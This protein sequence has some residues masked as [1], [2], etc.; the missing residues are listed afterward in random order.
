LKIGIVLPQNHKPSNGGGFSYV[1]ALVKEICKRKSD[2]DIQFISFHFQ[3]KKYYQFDASAADVAYFS[4]GQQL[5]K[6][7]ILAFY[8]FME[9]LSYK[10]NFFSWHSFFDKKAQFCSD[11]IL[12]KEGFR[13]LYYPFPE[14]LIG[15]DVPFFYTVWDLGHRN[16]GFFPDVASYP[17]FDRR[18]ARYTQA[19]KRAAK[20][21]VESKAGGQDVQFYYQV[22]SNKIVVLPMFGNSLQEAS[23]TELEKQE[24]MDKNKIKSKKYLFYPAQFWPHKN[25]INLLKAFQMLKKQGYDLQLLFTGQDKGNKGLIEKTAKQLNIEDAVL[26]LGFVDNKYIRLLYE[27]AFALVMPTFLGPTNMPLVEAM[28]LGCPVICTDFEG[29]REQTEDAALYFNP[30]SPDNI[31]EKILFLLQHEAERERMIEKGKTQIEQTKA[32]AQSA[33]DKLFVEIDDFKNVLSAW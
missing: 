29:H 10:L 22:K 32:T 28:T 8:L 33:V 5:L 23:Y 1:D 4:F 7:P 17:E 21:F 24:F 6:S 25:H 16:I 3:P 26:Y 12:K 31:A 19:T 30:Q 15:V 14:R 18:E 20:V 27:N 13:L 2:Y 9:R 11:K